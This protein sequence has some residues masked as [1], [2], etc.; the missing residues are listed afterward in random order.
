VRPGMVVQGLGCEP[1]SRDR[2]IMNQISNA[3]VRSRI[4]GPNSKGES[5]DGALPADVVGRPIPP[6]TPGRVTSGLHHRR[7][8]MPSEDVDDETMNESVQLLVA[9]PLTISSRALEMEMFEFG[10]QIPFTDRH[11]R[12]R[13]SG[14]YR[15][16]VQCPWRIV[17]SGRIV[18]GFDDILEPPTGASAEGF[19][20]NRA[21][22]T[23]RDELISR[24][25][26]ER[27]DAP[28]IVVS[29]TTSPV[30]DLRLV[31]DDESSLELLP[32][33]VAGDHWRL[34]LPDGV[35]I[36][37][38]AVGLRRVTPSSDG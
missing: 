16:H 31:F 36:V 30:G 15:L 25:H 3:D 11:G 9:Q 23:L 20:A 12:A 14:A 21:E 32:S 33:G 26:G 13:T 28:R 24:F 1:R 18:V 38:S 27:A 29:A 7:L 17:R 34:L 19:D 4:V 37:S 22:M 8:M 10:E 6:L 2:A 35:G 5:H